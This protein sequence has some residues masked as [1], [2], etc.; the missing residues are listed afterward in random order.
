MRGSAAFLAGLPPPPPGMTPA[1]LAAMAELHQKMASGELPPAAA[2]AVA[3]PP[4][5]PPPPSRVL[6][7]TGLIAAGA[8]L[9]N[10]DALG[11]L[12]D[13]TA[14]IGRAHV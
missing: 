14:E 5:P 8:D 13:A 2:A 1:M 6:R 11:E 4:P 10:Q 3:V 7:L 12:V 9:C